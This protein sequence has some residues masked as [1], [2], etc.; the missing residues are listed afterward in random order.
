[1]TV[2]R[3]RIQWRT[4]APLWQAASGGGVDLGRPAILRFATDDFMDRVQAVLTAGGEGLDGFLARN[5]TWRAPAAGLP[6]D[7]G[8]LKLFQPLQGR[9]YLVSATLVCSKR[10]L[11]D[12]MV[13]PTRQESAFFVLRQLRRRSAN[14]PPDPLNAATFSEYA[15]VPGA[16]GTGTWTPVPAPGLVA[17]EQR[18]P[19]FGIAYQALGGNRK[20]LAG[21]IPV[22]SR[23]R[24]RAAPAVPA[25]AGNDPLAGATDPRLAPFLPAIEGLIEVSR[26]APKTVP[27][28]AK[29]REAIYFD[30]L[31]LAE[32]VTD[33][34][35]A[36]LSVFTAKDGFRKGTTWRDAL[37]AARTSDPTAAVPKPFSDLL[38]TEITPALGTLGV[39]PGALPGSTAVFTQIKGLFPKPTTTTAVAVPAD[40]P[41]AEEDAVLVARCGYERPNCV[42]EHRLELSPPSAP[43]VF[44][45]LYD[46]D[47]PVRPS[48]IAMP[49]DLNLATLRKS[50]KGVSIALST[51]L[52]NQLNRFQAMKVSDLESGNTGSDGGFSF[53]MVCQLSIPIITIC[54]LILLMIIVALLN[55]VFWWLPL[56]KIC[57]PSVR[58]G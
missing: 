26:A 39:N 12:R 47:G 50:P 14:V 29:L 32:R 51:E 24:L 37:Q 57:F 9:F 20:L 40:D 22:G 11:P 48:Q 3:E 23:E 19:L 18:L 4:A 13:D 36:T 33:A 49:N 16:A 55:I 28:L 43:F 42:P 10:G 52:R 34:Q 46:P 25:D 54:A 27:A 2:L 7:T 15:W 53:G 35:A 17:S 58:R 5:E 41:Q 45:S 30:T 8:T 44:A 38:R 31:E 1:M 21:L 56:F 6:L